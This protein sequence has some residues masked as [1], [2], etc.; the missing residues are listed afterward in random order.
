MVTIISSP[1]ARKGELWELYRRHYGPDGDPGILVA[2]G[3]S[4]DFNPSLDEK[5][6]K[7]AL[8]RDE[9][10]A[11]AEYFAEFR[12]DLEGFASIEEVRACI[13]PGIKERR[14]ENRNA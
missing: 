1:Y 10:A 13:T 4:R 3:T 14:P 12:T 8:E 2:Q 9:S 5:V 11:R 6:V 7:R